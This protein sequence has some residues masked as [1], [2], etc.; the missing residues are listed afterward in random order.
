MKITVSNKNKFI[1]VSNKNKV[2]R[3]T[4]NKIAQVGSIGLNQLNNVTVTGQA[5]GDVLVYQSNTSTYVVK[6]LPKVDGGTY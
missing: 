1:L 2:G 6:S 4:F 3:V 5:E